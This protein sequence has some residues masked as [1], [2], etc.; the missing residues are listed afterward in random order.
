[1]NKPVA[2]YEVSCNLEKIIN[3]DLFLY[4][5]VVCSHSFKINCPYWLEQWAMQSIKLNVTGL[6]KFVARSPPPFPFLAVHL[7]A[8]H[9][10]DVADVWAIPNTNTT[11]RFSPQSFSLTVHA[12]GSFSWHFHTIKN[13]TASIS[14]AAPN[15]WTE[16]AV[17]T[18]SST[19]IKV[20]CG[21][22]L[23]GSLRSHTASPSKLS[24][25]LHYPRF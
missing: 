11:F 9:S 19:G 5:I 23:Y 3:L 16:V 6:S 13:K 20:V 7:A 10:H 14:T 1:M 24:C 18:A 8:W 15:W 25:S 2:K 4:Y 21:V 17:P 12:P 22:R